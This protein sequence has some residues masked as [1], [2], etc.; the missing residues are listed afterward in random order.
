MCGA[1]EVGRAACGRAGGWAS[2]APEV[3]LDGSR[4]GRTGRR[5]LFFAREPRAE[6]NGG[7]ENGALAMDPF[8]GMDPFPQG[9]RGNLVFSHSPEI[10]KK[11][12]KREIGEIG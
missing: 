12:K 3:G 10:K 2:G 6:R 5:S 1:P 9:C 4:L 8:P 7:D 11:I